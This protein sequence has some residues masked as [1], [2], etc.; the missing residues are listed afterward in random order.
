VE[1]VADFML[2]NLK[3]NK[4]NLDISYCGQ[5]NQLDIC[6]DCK[7]NFKLLLNKKLNKPITMTVFTPN[8][9]PKQNCK[10]YLK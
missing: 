8:L 4:M 7:R 6:N 5:R 10:G 2:M 1:F 9:T 3:K